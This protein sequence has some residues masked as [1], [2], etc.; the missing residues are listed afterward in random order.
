MADGSEAVNSIVPRAQAMQ[1]TGMKQ[2][3]P[4]LRT[5]ICLM[6]VAAC[7]PVTM[8]YNT[9]TE[10]SRLESD[11]LSCQVSAA[12]NVP[13]SN[14]VRRDPP[15]YYPA[16]RICRHDGSCYTRGGFFEPG[17]VYT[18]DVNAGL[19]TRVTDQCM[20]ERGYRE[21]SIPR[22]P[23]NVSRDAIPA[24]TRVLPPLTADSCILRNKDKT[25]QI[26]NTPG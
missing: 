25:W 26:L 20:A 9:G 8:Y 3:L 18:V 14:Q 10:V 21:V 11:L 23:S 2:V 1:Y 16:R 5:L 12:R 19:R 22:C 24:V 4:V 15:Q 13:V 6:L 7:A 17:D